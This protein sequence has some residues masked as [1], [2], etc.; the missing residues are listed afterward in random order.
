MPRLRPSPIALGAILFAG[1]LHLNGQ[2]QPAER[3]DS[4]S[5][6]DRAQAIARV[7]RI[8]ERLRG[9]EWTPGVVSAL[10]EL[11]TVACRHDQELG[12]RVFER[13]YS[14]AAGIDFDLSEESSIDVLSGLASGATRCH[15]EFEF[16]SPTDRGD[17]SE[18]EPQA[19]LHAAQASLGADPEAAAGLFQSAAEAFSDLQADDQLAFVTGLMILRRKQASEADAAF[20][21]ALLEAAS[22]GSVADLFALGNYIFGPP[23]EEPSSIAFKTMTFSEGK[24][25]AFPQTRP[26]IPSGLANLYLASSREMLFRKAGSGPESAIAFGLTKQLAD[27]AQSN[28][29]HQSAS[30]ASLLAAQRAQLAQGRDPSGLEARLRSFSGPLHTPLE[31]LL[32]S[33]PD[34]AAK[35]RVRFEHAASLIGR[36]DLEGAREVA[37]DLEDEIRRPMLDIIDLKR[38]SAAIAQGDLEAARLGL[39]TLSDDLHVVLAA[40]ELASAYWNQSGNAGDR[41]DE[42]VTAAAEAIELASA[43]TARVP[44]H[45]R[46][47]LRLAIARSLAVTGRFEESILTLELAV[48]EFNADQESEERTDGAHSVSVSEGGDVVAHVTR[49]KQVRQIRLLPRRAARA[50]LDEVIRQLSRSQEPDLDRLEG[51]VARA[52]DPRLRA[53]GLAAVAEGYLSH[54][55]HTVHRSLRKRV[56]ERR[57]DLG[58]EAAASTRDQET[59]D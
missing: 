11:G 46:P 43:A 10:S 17:S 31:E 33:V 41:S 2:E 45:V 53:L 3:A 47:A 39:A 40:L 26:G 30:L 24:I 37:T 13:A 55:F 21:H 56:A 15:P 18:L 42:N 48:Y 22:S 35:A 7:D 8:S 4:G 14:V 52:V 27:W 49:G 19:S 25:Y 9:M 54:S 6:G 57:T 29:P 23:A 34:E 1:G 12:I 5:R 50:T 59:P 16:R 51:V 20:Q 58:Q 28:A 36:G 32:E 44:E 38:I